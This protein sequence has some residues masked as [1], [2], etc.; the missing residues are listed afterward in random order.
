[1]TQTNKMTRTISPRQWHRYSS[2]KDLSLCYE[3]R[4]EDF[5]VHPPDISPTGMFINIAAGFPEGAILKV[6]FRLA[7]SNH[8]V[9]A[10]CEVRYC[11]LGVGVGVEFIDM[12]PTDQK[13]IAS[14]IKPHPKKRRR[15]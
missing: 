5:P 1:M 2:I 11:L 9:M 7:E 15:K 13:A 4:N 14:E 6:S 8:P 10:R 12:D 3:G